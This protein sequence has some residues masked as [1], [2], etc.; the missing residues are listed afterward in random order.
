METLTNDQS[1]CRHHWMLGQPVEGSIVA[2]CRRCGASRL[3][4]AYID[5]P[6]MSLE[7]ERRYSAVGETT[8]AGGA[9]PSSVRLAGESLIVI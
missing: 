5:D 4:P 7:T 9:R 1:P 2:V 8:A 6:E 3:Y